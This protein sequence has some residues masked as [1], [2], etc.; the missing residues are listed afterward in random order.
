MKPKAGQKPNHKKTDTKG[1]NVSAD[2]F[3]QNG[4]VLNGENAD[5]TVS[6]RS[7]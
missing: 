3:L 6:E 4:S 2:R 1:L 5:K 7:V